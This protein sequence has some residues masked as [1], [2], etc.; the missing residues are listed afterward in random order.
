MALTYGGLIWIYLEKL[1]DADSALIWSEKM[2]ADNPQNPWGYFYMGSAFICLDSLANAETFFR[3]ASDISPFF[4]LN[5]YRLAHVC[6]LRGHNN[7]AIL[8]LKKILEKSHDE[9]SAYYD[10]G[11]NYEAMG[12]IE[13]SRKNFSIFKKIGTDEWLK[14]YPDMAQTYLALSAVSARLGEMDYSRQMLQKATTI[15]SSLHFSFTEVLCLQGK[16]PEA[17]NQLERALKSGYRDLCW[18]KID[19]DLQPLSYDIR[20]HNLL[21]KY[22]KK[23]I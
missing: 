17:L 1:G 7:E 22:F 12:N 5:L 13:E 9:A 6:R 3:K 23:G 16:I 20:F 18:L 11:L 4:L 10:L 21:D 15:D 14:K 19:P 8:I 2:I